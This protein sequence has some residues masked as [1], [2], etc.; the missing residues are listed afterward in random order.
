MY[1]S[2][3]W[4]EGELTR[5]LKQHQASVGYSTAIWYNVLNCRPLYDPDGWLAGLLEIARQ[6]YPDE[7]RR[8]IIAKNYPLLR[9]TRSSYRQQ[10]EKSL[11]RQDKVSYNHRVAALLAS[12]F[13][14]LFAF[15]RQPHPGEKRLI[16]LAKKLCPHLPANFEADLNAW[17]DLPPT[18]E[19]APAI[20]TVMTH[21][22]DELDTLLVEK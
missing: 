21:L 4:T 12:Y 9:E 18:P 22:L 5:V 6:P 8:A 11:T 17:L 10:I 15:N 16:S 2:P 13:D 3:E 7:L 14:V 19:N 20:L 1:R